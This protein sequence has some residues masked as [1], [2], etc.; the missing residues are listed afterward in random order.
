[1]GESRRKPLERVGT[2][3]LASSLEPLWMRAL[4]VSKCPSQA[5]R[6]RGLRPD[7]WEG[8]R[9]YLVNPARRKLLGDHNSCAGMGGLRG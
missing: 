5:A 8:D 9:G 6:W 7:Y 3:S 4:Q 2:W 1:M